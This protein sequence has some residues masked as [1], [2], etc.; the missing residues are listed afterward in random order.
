MGYIRIG[1]AEL[2]LGLAL[3]PM[4]GVSDRA[5]RQVCR[6]LGAEYTVSEMVS[7]KA[8]LMEQ[9]TR[10]NGAPAHVKPVSGVLASVLPE[11]QPMAVQL[12][13]HEPEVMAGAARLLAS[14]EYA[15]LEGKVPPAAIDINMGCPVRKITGNGEGSALLRDPDLAERIVRA[16]TEAVSLPV[17]VKLRAGWDQDTVNAPELARRCEAA[18]AS[19]ICIHGRTRAQGYAPGVDR[20]VIRAVKQ[21][22]SIPVMGNGDIYT[23]GDALSMMAETGCDG[24]MIARGALG[25]PW[26][27]AEIRAA[28]LGTDFTPP[29]PDQRFDVALAQVQ[30]MIAEKGERVGLAEA[31]KHLAWYCHGLDGAAAYRGRIMQAATLEE[32]EQA[33]R[34]LAASQD[35]RLRQLPPRDS[36]QGQELT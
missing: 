36:R 20:T 18:G 27:F 22:V 30:A 34:E 28:L 26:L 4:A 17:T 35:G 24:V 32:M 12:F 19:M 8:L 16:V 14:G 13:G 23:A 9:A 33:V 25:N 7:A 21:A 29:T 6:R 5:M 1:T 3:A 31:K 11:E 15:G 10:K 2:T